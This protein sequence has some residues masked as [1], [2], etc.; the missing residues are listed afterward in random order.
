MKSSKFDIIAISEKIMEWKACTAAF[1]RQQFIFHQATNRLH[2]DIFML[3]YVSVQPGDALWDLGSSF[4][5]K[6]VF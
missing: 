6:A 5:L 3:R 1:V 4:K 2:E